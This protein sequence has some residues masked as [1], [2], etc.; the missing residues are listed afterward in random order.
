MTDSKMGHLTRYGVELQVT[1]S[2]LG[3]SVFATRLEDPDGPYVLHKDAEIYRAAVEGLREAAKAI[4]EWRLVETEN[5][6]AQDIKRLRAAL[7]R[8]ES[9][10]N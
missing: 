2:I 9:G 5:E 10:R 7:A 3:V 1:G 6:A 8:L 4:A